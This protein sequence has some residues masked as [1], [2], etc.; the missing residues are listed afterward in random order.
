MSTKPR[1][2][3]TKTAT[4]IGRK[5]EAT[6]QALLSAARVVIARDGFANARIADISRE[7]G[8]AVGVFYSYFRDKNELFSALVDAFLVD[9][10]RLTPTPNAYEEHTAAAVRTAVHTFWTS[11]RHFHPEMLGL[12]ESA[13]SDP[14]L[15]E[16]WRKIRARSIRRF[17]FRIRKQQEKGLCLDLDP[18]LAASALSGMLEF[19]CFN[20]HSLKLD[21]PGVQIDD[22]RA[23]QTLY[24]LIARVLE[25]SDSHVDSKMASSSRSANSMHRA[26]ASKPRRRESVR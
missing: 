6:R 13:L 18:E 26:K 11:Y 21:Y 12:F 20:W 16:I 25:L 19:T 1:G 5:A 2:P 8:K 4:G 3:V 7:A 23:V 14:A 10:T 24:D 17:A 9:L 22:E 15:L